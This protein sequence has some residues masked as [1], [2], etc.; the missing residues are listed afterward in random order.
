MRLDLPREVLG[1]LVSWL[2]PRRPSA[3][4]MQSIPDRTPPRMSSLAWVMVAKSS[5]QRIPRGREARN[6]QGFRKGDPNI[7]DDQVS[8]EEVRDIQVGRSPHGLGVLRQ[9]TRRAARRSRS[10][11]R[12]RDL[13]NLLHRI[14]SSICGDR[15]REP[16]R[17]VCFTDLRRQ[18]HSRRRPYRRGPRGGIYWPRALQTPIDR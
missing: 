16:R 5:D 13:C 4:W 8:T 12:R 9:S 7:I 2:A 6:Q 3:A 15:R 17:E 11:R 10:V 1:S 14:V 18:G